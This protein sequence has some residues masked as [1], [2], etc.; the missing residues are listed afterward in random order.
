MNKQ[1]TNSLKNKTISSVLW[2]GL[3]RTSA[4]LVSAI[5]S[6]VL[7]RIL[8]PDDY[9]V[10]S[11]VTIFFSFCNIFISGGLNTAL[12]QKKDSDDL[13]Y[14]TIFVANEF[15]AT[16]LYAI[17]F[18]CAPLIASLFGK[19]LLVPIVRVMG[20]SFFV[21]GYKAVLSARISSN[22]EFRKFFYSTI[23]GTII[24]A[25]IGIILAVKGFGPW[26]LVA[27]QLT[28]T[29]ID[30]LV[31]SF[32]SHVKLKFRF[33]KKRFKIL[34]KF[35]GK[36]MVSSII[37]ETYN[38]ARPLIVGINYST[39]DLAYYNKGKTYPD[40]FCSIGNDT[41]SAALFP[42]MSKVQ[43]DRISILSMTRR[44]MQLSSFIVFP[45]MI[46]FLAISKGFVV[47]VLTEKWLP[48]VPYLM[49]FCI[50]SMFNPI[51]RGNLQAIRAI[52]RSDVFLILEIIKKTSYLIIILLFVFLTHDPIVLAAS[53]I[54]TSLL[55]SLIN[56]F[57]NRKLLGYG[58]RMQFSD[59]F[60]NLVT[61]SIMGIIVYF[62]KDLPFNIYLVTLIQILSGII[63]YF[64]LNI[65]IKNSSLL[66]LKAS[67]KGFLP[68][69]RR[70]IDRQ[71]LEKKSD[72]NN[73]QGGKAGG[74]KEDC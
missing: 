70:T 53:G 61:S 33:S 28:N 56:S 3:E 13:D 20:L 59:L 22:L 1:Q 24:S 8:Y 27:Q 15:M 23:I 47:I 73:K 10:V 16:I 4:Q 55:A 39:T 71:G 42:A 25:P 57:P 74:N 7:A 50:S 6:I 41:L 14:S 11:V 48:I 26:A 21:S 2:K 19:E 68:K 51:Q 37:N 31:L 72:I 30:S 44:F 63:I 62:M 67:I 43:D 49:L 38:Q 54:I 58:Y 66:Y 29:C 69:Q 9:S 60:T 35:G 36:I 34:F 65:I 12:I 40:L 18:F 45:M 46:G 64:G 32:T 5:V 17:M 52:G